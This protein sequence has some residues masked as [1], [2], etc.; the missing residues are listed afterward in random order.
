MLLSNEAVAGRTCGKL[1]ITPAE[2]GN[3][4]ETR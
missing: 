2:A 3:C 1:H 4:H